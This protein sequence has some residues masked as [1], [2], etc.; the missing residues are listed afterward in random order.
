[1]EE[2]LGQQ[3]CNGD[4]VVRDVL[5]FI[6]THHYPGG[7]VFD[8]G[9][10]DVSVTMIFFQLRPVQITLGHDNLGGALRRGASSSPK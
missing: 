10:Q 4:Y 2:E 8:V 1:M 5:Y 3:G 7:M 6:S 9:G